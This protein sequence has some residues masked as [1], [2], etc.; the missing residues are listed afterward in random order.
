MTAPVSPIDNLI[1]S[2]VRLVC[3]D[4]KGRL[5]SGTGYVFQF[6]EA[7][8]QGIPCV[9][10]NKH[11]VNGATQ[12]TFNL[13]LK[14]EVDGPSLGQHERVVIKQLSDFY[15]EH[16]DPKIDLV[17]IPIGPI[18]NRAARGGTAYHF[19]TLSWNM[20]AS[21]DLLQS[22]STM[23]DI[24]MIGYPNGLWDETHNL[25]IIRKGVTA[26][27]ARVPLNNKPEFLID[28]ACFPGSSGSPVFLANLGGYATKDS[29]AIGTRIALLGT[30]Y[31]GPQHT[32]EGEIVVVEIPTDTKPIA[33]GTIPNNL[34]YVIQ[35][36]QLSGLELA[37]KERLSSMASSVSRNET[38]RC[39][40]GLKFKN[41]CGARH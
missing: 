37:L 18:L 26:T 39:G 30:L 19:V 31:G 27:H 14:N 32:T 11:V 4:A 9:V 3:Q 33:L 15:V 8:G 12:G 36:S 10:T 20:I 1:H 35:A 21:D 34:G 38:C 16:P 6:C 23:E 22:I 7:D 17:A 2:T 5:S 29:W 24:V 41:C 40:S 25:P 28:A 13:T